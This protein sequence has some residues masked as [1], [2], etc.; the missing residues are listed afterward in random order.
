VSLIGRVDRH[1]RL[2]GTRAAPASIPAEALMER[3]RL[4]LAAADPDLATLLGLAAA[5]SA[6]DL[7]RVEC[8]TVRPPELAVIAA[9]DRVLGPLVAVAGNAGWRVRPLVMDGAEILPLA[10]AL[11]DPRVTA[12]LAGASDP[13]GA[14][15]RTLLPDLGALVAAAT[16]RRPDLV[17]VLAGGL[18]EPGGRIEALFQPGRPGPTLLAPSP[19]VGDGEPLRE[20]LD[21]L[22]GGTLDGRRSLAIATGT[23]AAVLQRR[24]ELLEIGQTGATRVAAGWSGGH[25]SRTRWASVPTAALLPLAFGEPHLDAILGWLAVPPDRLRVRDRL[26]EL[27]LAPWGD[28]AGDGALLRMA[29][30]RAALG[31]LLAATR[32][33]DAQPA[34]DLIVAAGGVWNVAPALAVAFALADAVRRPGAWAM[35]LDHAR[36]LGPLGTIEDE[37]E[38]RRV[39]AD[40]R[41]DILVPLGSVVMPAGLRPGRSAGHLNVRRRDEPP[42]S[43]EAGTS[44]AAGD[45]DLAPGGL[46]VI[47]LPPG[48]RAVVEMRFRDPVDL[49]V[50]VRHAAVE[51]VG[52]IGGVLVDL[53]D[54]PMRLPDTADLRR[55]LLG[56]WQA[57]S[58]PGLDP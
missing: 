43:D 58:W 50:P 46:E 16:D 38:R 10:S 39:M 42:R 40:L 57:A 3:L 53:R 55:E 31:R 2:L 32:D 25:A 29:A 26:R 28:A 21:G 7:P 54:V 5:G 30:A 48:A 9:T 27:A 12:I 34:P 35:G 8:V 13:P 6:A 18:A 52:G 22:R 49:G 41:D 47:D 1:W 15:E 17:T 37:D 44:P 14:D 23:L 33:L 45:L 19:A 24:V 11:A 51:V 36:L 56:T 20:L 4:G